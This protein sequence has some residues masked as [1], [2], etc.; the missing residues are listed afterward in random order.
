MGDND[1]A[2]VNNLFY[3][4]SASPLSG[5][6]RNASVD[7]NVWNEAIYLSNLDLRKL[8]INSDDGFSIST[9]GLTRFWGDGRGEK[10][11]RFNTFLYQVPALMISGSLD[12]N[13]ELPE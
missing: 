3:N 7:S 10:S 12:E 1:R 13:N 4:Y 9:D 11:G 6:N 2:Y 8:N 5:N